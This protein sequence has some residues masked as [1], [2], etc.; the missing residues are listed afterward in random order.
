MMQL[1]LCLA[2]HAGQVVSVEQLLDEVWK[3]VVVTPDS[4]YHAVAALRRVLGDDSKDPS[5]IA[6]VMRRGY[7]LIAPVVPLGIAEALAPPLQPPHS[8]AETQAAKPTIEVAQ[9][10]FIRKL[11]ARRLHIA[12]I[13]VLGCLFGRL[14]ERDFQRPTIY[15]VRRRATRHRVQFTDVGESWCADGCGW[16]SPH[17]LHELSLGYESAAFEVTAASAYEPGLKIRV[18]VFLYLS[19]R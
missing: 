16:G 17:Q 10:Q 3:D 4:V 8:A 2:A 7:R 14:V 19:D 12:I 15:R 18:S 11:T 13:T 9:C 6:N 5:D 1:L